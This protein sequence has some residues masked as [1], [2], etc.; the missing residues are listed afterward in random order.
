MVTICWISD[1]PLGGSSFGH[2]TY[3]ITKRLGGQYQIYILSLNYEGLPIKT[4]PKVEILPLKTGDQ[5]NYYMDKLK[6]DYSIVHHSFYFLEHI[7]DVNLKGKKIAY[8]PV[9]GDSLPLSYKALLTP[10]DLILTPSMYSQSILRK[11]GLDAKVVPHGVDT[12]FFVPLDSSQ[13]KEVRFGYLGQN[14]IRKQIPRVMEAY[15]K[16]GKGILTIAATNSGAYNLVAEAKNLNIAPI[17]IEKKLRGLPLSSENLRE[18]YQSLSIY[19]SP[20]TEGFGLPSLEAAACGVCNICLDHG[21]AREVM[22]SGAVYCSV[23]SYL[24]TAMGKIGLIDVKDLFQKMRF[25]M[26]VPDARKRTA[27]KGLDR[28]KELTWEKAIAKLEVEKDA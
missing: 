16:L 12:T 14:D 2:V 7:K 13:W 21:A 11:A 5:L 24:H 23:E 10:Y 4:Q 6:P 28:A 19:I 20:A 17:F 25:L 15:S 22:G 1:F 26:D 27:Q 18:F 8:I 9:E 3:E